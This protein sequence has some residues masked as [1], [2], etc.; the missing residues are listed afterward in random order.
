MKIT[1][2]MLFDH[3]AE[4]RNIWL[5]TLPADEDLPAATFSKSFERKMRKL[6][7]QQRRTPRANQTIRYIR[8]TAA[9]ILLI[10]IFTFGGL[11]T[12]E[13]YR[14]KVIDI[15]IEVFEE[16]TQ[17]RFSSDTSEEVDTKQ[18]ELPQ[19][20]F[21]YI[22]EG[23]QETANSTNPA[24]SLQIT[25]EDD[26]NHFFDLSVIQITNGEYGTILDTE[27]SDY[28]E[29]TINGCEAYF[30]TKN[31]CSSIMWIDENIVYDLY[32]YMEISELKTVAENIKIFPS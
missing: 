22:P 15:V 29:G 12:V 14:E 11:M 25:Y 20:Q 24:E 10:A 23:M 1:D 21:G 7:R 30:N 18:T 32:G 13:A 6:I 8:H 3:A 31:G 17:Y 26:Q 27:D 9:A 19:I 2:E 16:F 5:K 28:W 4:A